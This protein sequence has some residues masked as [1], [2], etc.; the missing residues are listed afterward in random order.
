LR[1][2]RQREGRFDID[3]LTRE[4]GW[5]R[6]HLERTFLERAGIGP[7]AFASVLRFHAVYKRIRAS[8]GGPYAPLIHDHYYD[9]SHFLKAF[10]RYTGITRAS[11]RVLPTTGASTSL[12]SGE[13]A[14]E[15]A[16]LEESPDRPPVESRKAVIDAIRRQYTHPA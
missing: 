14:R 8:A 6:R 2:R 12:T 3:G 15:I 13:L 10:K 1:L 7:K 16:A 11:I 9:Q 4:V 5:S